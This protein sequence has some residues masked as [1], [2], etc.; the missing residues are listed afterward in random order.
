MTEDQQL[1]VYQKEVDWSTTKQL[2]S[3]LDTELSVN[4]IF[5]CMVDNF[6][7]STTFAKDNK[8]GLHEHAAKHIRS[9]KVEET[10]GFK[11]Y[12]LLRIEKDA[13]LAI[14]YRV[15]PMPWYVLSQ[16]STETTPVPPAVLPRVPL[17]FF[18]SCLPHR[19]IHIQTLPRGLIHPHHYQANFR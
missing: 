16:K 9:A 11:V 10:V 4:D 15:T 13:V 2:R 6:T 8:G 19:L 12:P 5:D 14:Q 18:F 17:A 3:V 1:D 7:G